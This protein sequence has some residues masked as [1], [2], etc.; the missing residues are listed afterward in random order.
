M[1]VLTVDEVRE[2]LS[3]Y[4]ERNLLLDEE[5][6]STTF[7]TLCMGLGV[8]TFNSMAPVTNFNVNTLPAKDLLLFGTCFH[9]FQGKAALLARNTM[10]YSD[11]GLQIP[12]EERYELYMSLAGSFKN[13]F[14]AS[15]KALKI[16]INMEQGWGSLSG[17]A[18]FFPIW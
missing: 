4:P 6:F 11:G 2:Y 10:Q 7:I 5:E 1:A 3:D 16:Q 18:A 14:D 17:D 9:M 12:I 15:A 13:L 8:S